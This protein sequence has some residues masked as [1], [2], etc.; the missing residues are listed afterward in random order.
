MLHFAGYQTAFADTANPVRTFHIHRD[1]I[2]CQ[3]IRGGLM[4]RDI[5]FTPLL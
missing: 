3:H 2:L 5:Q 1:T 4:R